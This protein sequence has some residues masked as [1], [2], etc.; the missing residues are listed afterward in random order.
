MTLAFFLS[1]RGYTMSEPR[2]LMKCPECGE[3]YLIPVVDSAAAEASFRCR[4][5]GRTVGLIGLHLD[6]AAGKRRETPSEDS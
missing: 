4:L 5:C 1:N 3:S 6:D 2:I